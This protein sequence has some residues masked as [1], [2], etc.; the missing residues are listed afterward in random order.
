MPILEREIPIIGD[1]YVDMEFGAG[2]LKV[3]PGHDFNDYELAQKH[4]LELLNILN[5]NA[6]MNANAGKYEGLDRYECREQL[7][8]DM[9]AL[10]MTIKTEP[11]VTRIPRSQRGGEVVEPMMS[12]Q[13]YVRIQPLADKA[14]AAVR[15]G[16]VKIVPE[17]FERS[18][19][20]GWR[21]S[22]T[23]ASAASSGGGIAS[24]PGIAK[25]TATLKAKSMSAAQRRVAM[26]G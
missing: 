12:T 13:W 9:Q 6:S 18:T 19:F 8:R 7:W 20:I 5:K 2:A 22:R 17:R 23:G 1:E 3:T 4:D 15:D 10:G 24:R 25:K 16:R 14:I 11:Y 26:A 21:I